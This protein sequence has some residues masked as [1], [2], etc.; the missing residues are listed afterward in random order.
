[1]ELLFFVVT[2]FFFDLFLVLGS[3]V[4]ILFIK[5]NL[6]LVSIFDADDSVGWLD[7][8]DV[9]KLTREDDVGVWSLLDCSK[10]SI[11]DVDGSVYWFDRFD[12]FKRSREDEVGVW[13]LL[14]R[15]GRSALLFGSVVE[16]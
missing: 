8:F 3:S 13:S 2:F 14:D 16:E 7:R 4:S 1:M 5:L 10:W 12:N 15:G 9:F 6:F 11:F